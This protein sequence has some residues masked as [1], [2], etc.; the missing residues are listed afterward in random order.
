M[1]LRKKK[2]W[3]FE[4]LIF[5]YGIAFYEYFAQLNYELKMSAQFLFGLLINKCILY[6]KDHKDWLYE[7][8][9][10]EAKWILI[11]ILVNYF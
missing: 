7:K 1:T 5:A 2:D 6:D 4:I 9:Y 10:F 11:K 8:I 3:L